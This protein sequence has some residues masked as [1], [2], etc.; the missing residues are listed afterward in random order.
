MTSYLDFYPISRFIPVSLKFQVRLQVRLS[1][2]RYQ[3]NT[4][5]Q[6]S[7]QRSSPATPHPRPRL[8]NLTPLSTTARSSPEATRYTA[9]GLTSTR[10]SPPTTRRPVHPTN[11]PVPPPTCAARATRETDSHTH[12]T[13]RERAGA[14]PR[15]WPA[16]RAR[17]CA[18]GRSP[19]R[20]MEKARH[21]KRNTPPEAKHVTGSETRHRK[22]TKMPG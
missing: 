8:R 3:E 9:L 20:T 22:Q 12:N 11:S 19:R 4:Q 14:Q 6:A 16:P 21:Q 13:T 10:P 5:H 18:Y 7:A 17:P 15:D 1:I 2:Q